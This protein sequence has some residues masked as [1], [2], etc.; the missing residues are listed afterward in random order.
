MQYRACDKILTKRDDKF[1]LEAMRYFRRDA[2][3]GP[4]R[5]SQVR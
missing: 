3:A 4:Q 1:Q 5:S 2:Y